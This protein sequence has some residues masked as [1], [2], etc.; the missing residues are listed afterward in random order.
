MRKKIFVLF[1]AV[2][3]MAAVPSVALADGREEAQIN[4]TAERT[5]HF[6]YPG[7]LEIPYEAATTPVGFLTV[8]ELLL[9]EGERLVITAR[10]DALTLENGEARLP[11]TVT[12]TAFPLETAED[13]AWSVAVDIGEADWKN[14]LE[15]RYSGV[16]EWTVTSSLTGEELAKAETALYTTVPKASP[17]EPDNPSPGTGERALPILCVVVLAVGGFLMLAAAKRRRD[18]RS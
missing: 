7:D 5:F 12:G 16:I 6:Q 2:F 9:Y 1:A 13:G 17:T 4:A 18:S 11:F 3:L 15:G 14:A 10:Y 8:K